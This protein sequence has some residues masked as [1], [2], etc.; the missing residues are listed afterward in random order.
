V[1]NVEL[2]LA[3]MVAVAVVATAARALRV[4]YPIL[5]V[6]GGLLLAL[7]PGMPQVV[8]APELIFLLFLPP[9]VYVAS[10]DISPRDIRAQLRPILSLA[11]GLVLASTLLVG[12]IA[13]ALLP[14]IGWPVAF[15]LGAMLSATDAVAATALLLI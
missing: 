3:L 15:T 7:T 11:V 1:P 14:E 6:V 12:A 8:L 4:P 5:L 2:I 9:L 13:H 10:F